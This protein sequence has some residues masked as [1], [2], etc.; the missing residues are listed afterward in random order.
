MMVGIV[1][2]FACEKPK[3][4]LSFNSIIQG[5]FSEHLI[6]PGDI[7]DTGAYMG[8]WA[9]MY[10]CFDKNRMVYAVDPSPNNVKKHTCIH[11]NIN[12][13]AALFSNEIGSIQKKS[14]GFTWDRSIKKKGNVIMTTVD[15]YFT[16]ITFGFMHLDVEGFELKVLQG[17]VST[18]ERH[19]PVITVESHIKNVMLTADL[20]RFLYGL[21]YLVFVVHEICGLANSC[22]NF[23]CIPMESKENFHGS[24]TMDLSIRSNILTKVNSTSVF[25]YKSNAK[26]HAWKDD[27]MFS[28]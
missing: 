5:M 23:I 19:R 4:E 24:S 9:C 17:A 11:K 2:V 14:G 8:I 18:I 3:T 12:S 27:T 6:P 16:G 1:L 10:A 7:L 26:L 22:R 25:H 15:T 20:I 21:R 13:T 28:H